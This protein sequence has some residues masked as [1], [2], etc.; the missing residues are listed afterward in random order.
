LGGELTPELEKKSASNLPAA[1]RA[2]SHRNFRLFFAGQ[3]I[4]LIGTWMQMVAESWLVYRLTDSAFLLG[5][6]GFAGQIPVFLFA[7]IGGAAADRWDRKR[8]ILTAQVASM[9]LAFL[10]AGLTLFG[11]IQVWHVL[12]LA[13]LL[14]IVNAFDM[15]ARQAFVLDLVGREDLFSAVALNSFT[16]NGARVVGP[17]VAGVLVAALGE[18]WCFFLNAGSYLAVIAGLLAMRLPPRSQAPAPGTALAR[19]AEGF[20]FVAQTGP[21][22]GLLALLAVV[23]LA[24][25]PYI[26][27]M[28][29]FADRILNGGPAALGLLMGASGIGAA[30]GGLSLAGRRNVRGLGRWIVISM[31]AFG[32]SLLLFSLSRHLWLSV[33]LLVPAGFFMMVQMAASNTLIQLMVPDELRGRVMSVYAMTFMGM[34]PLGSLAAGALAERLGAP[35]TVMIGAAACI[36]TAVFSVFRLTALRA[37]AR[38]LILGQQPVPDPP[39]DPA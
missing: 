30:A 4:S 13:A 22:R 29:L 19:I 2:L 5:L 3:L 21:I 7:P 23:S 31:A 14:G 28:P 38:Q 24:G 35:L 12:V 25:M 10:L 1:F 11:V 18:G 26:V 9:L 20:R 36:A 15:P 8:I 37:E 34:A 32:V 6:V 16:F 17:A 33:L 27:L 39:R